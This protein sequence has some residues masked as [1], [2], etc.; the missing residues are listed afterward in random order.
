MKYRIRKHPTEQKWYVETKKWY[1]SS[2]NM[3]D[4]VTD[5][6]SVEDRKDKNIQETL[7]EAELFDKASLCAKNHKNQIIYEI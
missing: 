5:Y 4:W 1:Q 6:V 2:W 7:T 3:L